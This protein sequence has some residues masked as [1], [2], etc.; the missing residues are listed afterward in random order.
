M[1]DEHILLSHAVEQSACA[2]IITDVKG[3]I[4][5]VNKKFSQL[6]GY[7]KE[8]AMG[9]NP[10]ILKSGEMP[11]EEYKNLWDTITS[12]KDWNGEFHNKKK[13]GGYYWTHAKIS[14]VRNKAGTITHFVGIQEDITSFKLL[15]RDFHN[16]VARSADGIIVVDVQGTVRFANPM[17]GIA[18]GSSPEKIVGSS[19]GIPVVSGEVAEIDI[20]RADSAL[21]IAEL[22]A[23]DTEWEGRKALLVMIRDVT[24]R[25]LM[26]NKIHRMAYYDVL[27]GLPNRSSFDERFAMAI[28]WAGRHRKKV[29][30]LFLDI[31]HFKHIN[32][33]FGHQEGDNFLKIVAHRLEKCVR[34]VDTVSRLGGDEFTVLLAEIASAEDI[35]KVVQKLLRVVKEPIS[36]AGKEVCVSTSIGIAFYPENGTNAETLLKNADAAM[37]S[38]KKQGRNRYQF[39]NTSFAEQEGKD[40][41]TK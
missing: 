14:P 38:A 24:D 4:E 11:Q 21:G 35:V 15:H 30:V 28:A 36:L 37:Y 9:Q 26:E 13:D 34:G 40:A 25:K 16:I 5:Y 17:A 31:D 41:C 32:D 33:C 39:F 7:A 12:G 6:T 27:T 10:R 22:R 19:F 2:V 20:K 8:E 29:A 3:T 18:L 1:T 23:A